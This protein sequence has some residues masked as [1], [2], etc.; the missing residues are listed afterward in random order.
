MEALREQL[1]AQLDE[2]R[3]LE[4]MYSALGEFHVCSP[5]A[6]D[7]IESFVEGKDGAT[8]EPLESLGRLSFSLRLSCAQPSRGE[9]EGSEGEEDTA[10][11]DSA[12]VETHHHVIEASF[13][14]PHR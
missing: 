8:G 5:A 6:M 14:L 12:L 1:S 4:S 3:L 2:A 11:G 13:S 10:T 9:D 7:A